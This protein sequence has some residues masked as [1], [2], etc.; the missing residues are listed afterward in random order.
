M[1]SKS[2]KDSRD[3][4]LVEFQTEYDKL[5]TQY[6]SAL[7]AAIQEPDSENQQELIQEVLNVNAEMSNQVRDIIGIL[8][9]GTK[10]V[11]VSTLDI[12]TKQLIDYQKQNSDIKESKDKV[13]TLKMIQSA[14]QEK[15]DSVSWMYMLYLFALF[16]L[17]FI[18]SYLA[19]R[20]PGY[21]TLPTVSQTSQPILR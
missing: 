17:I 13:T 5:R 3:T 14:S 18:V 10:S 6:S 8:N 20:T 11:D 21:F 7:L 1:E 9:Q 15:I 2:F 12:L 16:A 19:I 4:R